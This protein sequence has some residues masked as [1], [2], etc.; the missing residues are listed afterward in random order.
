MRNG[1]VEFLAKKEEI[2]ADLQ[3]GW[4]IRAIHERLHSEGALHFSYRQL[5][6]YLREV[7]EREFFKQ[8]QRIQD[9]LKNGWSPRAIYDE[10]REEGLIHFTYGQMTT[11]ISEMVAGKVHGK[12][13]A[14]S[15]TNDRGTDKPPDTGPERKKPKIGRIE[16]EPFKYNPNADI[17]DFIH[18]KPPKE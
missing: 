15:E 6:L 5:Q 16:A 17:S 2:L 14:P 9:Y 10:L 12:T 7:G 1:R 11:Y 13:V 8:R 3:K 18:G 4:S